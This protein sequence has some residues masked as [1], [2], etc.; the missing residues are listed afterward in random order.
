MGKTQTFPCLTKG[1]KGTVTYKGV[2]PIANFCKECREERIKIQRRN[3]NARY[4]GREEEALPEVDE[5]LREKTR[6]KGAT[7]KTRKKKGEL[8]E[9]ENGMKMAQTEAEFINSCIIQ[10]RRIASRSQTEEST[11]RLRALGN[12]QTSLSALVEI[13]KNT[14]GN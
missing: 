14:R 11:A 12:A 8:N 13:F 1:C 9:A 3:E 4:R 2:G 10:L 7:R 5:A 6:G